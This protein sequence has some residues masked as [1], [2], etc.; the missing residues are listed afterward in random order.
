MKKEIPFERWLY[1]N[2]Y[3]RQAFSKISGLCHVTIQKAARGDAIL[4]KCALRILKHTAPDLTLDD[5]KLWP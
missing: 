3:S 2:R 5:F 1:K 4:R